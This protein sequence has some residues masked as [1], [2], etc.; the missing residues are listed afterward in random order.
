MTPK[1]PDRPK[2]A[3]ELA[4]SPRLD[5]AQTERLA[6]LTRRID[7]RPGWVDRA[8]FAAVLEANAG[9]SLDDPDDR[10]AVLEALC[11]AL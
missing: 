9:R 3:Q 2:T 4:A 6:G 8:K 5:P 11:A 10:A 7:Q 1:L